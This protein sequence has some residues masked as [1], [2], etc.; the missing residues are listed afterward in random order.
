MNSTKRSEI[1]SR[2]RAR[3]AVPKSEL[4]Y[5]SPFDL[6]VSVILSAQAT[7]KSVNLATRELY[8][9]ARTPESILALGVAGL[10]N[11]IKRIGLFRTKAKNIVATCQMLLERHGGA[12][13]DT[14]EALEQLQIGRAHV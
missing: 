4:E 9:V 2:L 14:H 1:F 10:E 5:R 8:A 6:L 3:N 7:D 13:P 12:V 11:H